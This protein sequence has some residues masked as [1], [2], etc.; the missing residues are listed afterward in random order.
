MYWKLQ[1][2]I[3]TDVYLCKKY[4]SEHGD[5]RMTTFTDIAQ[6][7]GVA[8]STISRYLNGG[9]V[10]YETK[11]KIENIISKAGY[12]PNSFAQSLKAKKTNIIGIIVP[13]LDSYATSRTLIGIDEKLKERNYQILVSNSNQ[14]SYKQ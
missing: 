11:K 1:I 10:S 14:N 4:I 8:K 2:H 5:E 3:I 9:S 7:A 6:M 13:H 12:T